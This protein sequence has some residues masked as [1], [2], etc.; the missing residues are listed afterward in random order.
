M[1]VYGGIGRDI[2]K[3]VNGKP[4]SFFNWYSDVWELY[5]LGKTSVWV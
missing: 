2:Y 4:M 3:I 5:V 1:I